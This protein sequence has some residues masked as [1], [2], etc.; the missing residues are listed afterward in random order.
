MTSAT[1]Q[2]VAARPSTLLEFGRAGEAVKSLLSGL[3]EFPDAPGLLD[4]LARAQLKL[5]PHAAVETAAR[6]IAVEPDSHRGYLL[7]SSAQM[8]LGRRR[9]AVRLAELAVTRAPH[10]GACHAQLA[11]SLAG[12]PLRYRRARSAART[13]LKL[14]PTDPNVHIAAGVVA[15][16]VGRSRQASRHYR[17]ALELDPTHSVAQTNHA[18]VRQEHGNTAKALKELSNAIQ[19]DPKNAQPRRAFDG[20]IYRTI[21]D[22]LI[23]WIFV[24]MAVTV[25]RA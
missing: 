17:A 21:C 22:L 4:L 13:G 16:G 15:F 1:P 5:D 2:L 20:L 10:S 3:A 23:V 11:Q 7:A 25:L 8:L 9:K 19:L 12:H 6:L 24:N 18:I 14:A